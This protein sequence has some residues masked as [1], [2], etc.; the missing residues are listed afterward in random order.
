VSGA[1]VKLPVPAFSAAASGTTHLE[2]TLSAAGMLEGVSNEGGSL[3]GAHSTVASAMVGNYTQTAAGALN[4][5]I[6]GTVPGSLYDR[7]NI[8]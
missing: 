4:M 8:R 2:G 5:E 3:S 1:T 6:G 7:L